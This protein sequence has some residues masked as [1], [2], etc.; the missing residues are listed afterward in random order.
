MSETSEQTGF[1]YP[2]SFVTEYGDELALPRPT[3]KVERKVFEEVGKILRDFPAAQNLVN[4]FLSG[5]S[6]E[7]GEE[8][9]AEDGGSFWESVDILDLLQ[10]V[11]TK[12]PETLSHI[13]MAILGMESVDDVEEVLT[14]A[15]MVR[16]IVLFFRLQT[17][18]FSGVS[19]RMVEEL[20]LS[21]QRLSQLA[22]QAVTDE[23]TG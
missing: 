21:R 12:V 7:A 3:A 6:D 16:L 20:G 23:A 8:A 22:D 10:A 2:D 4:Q 9:E 14:Y 13:S 1:V 5:K 15:D 17:S 11:M 18:R 19:V